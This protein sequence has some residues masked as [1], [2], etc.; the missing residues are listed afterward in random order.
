MEDYLDKHQDSNF[1]SDLPTVVSVANTTSCLYADDTSALSCA[2]S[3]QEVTDALTEYAR[4]LEAYSA[5]NGLH[6]N[7]GKTQL[8]YLGPV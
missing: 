8:M 2:S 5:D 4:K 1:T 6:L 3:W 7:M